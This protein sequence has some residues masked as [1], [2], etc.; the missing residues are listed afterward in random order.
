[1]MSEAASYDHLVPE[2]ILKLKT[3]IRQVP[4]LTSEVHLLGGVGGPDY[5]GDHFTFESLKSPL[6]VRSQS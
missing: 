2:V 5:K 3:K 1:M 4:R 6:G